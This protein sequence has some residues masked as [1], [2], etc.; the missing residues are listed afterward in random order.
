MSSDGSKVAIVTGASRGIGAAI[1]TRLAADGFA[2]I[3]NYARR[4]AGTKA[5]VAK[6]EA[7]G[8]R[9]VSAQADVSDPVAVE[10][11]FDSAQTAFGGIDVLV[12]NA[13]IMKLATIEGHSA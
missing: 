2:V 12:N 11:M 9:A 3:V 4:A 13:G 1:A 7:T 6:I 10:R 8:G 5:L